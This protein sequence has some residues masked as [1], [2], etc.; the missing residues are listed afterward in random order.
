M[1]SINYEY[2][3]AGMHTLCRVKSDKVI[4]QTDK[5]IL[6]IMAESSS[7]RIIM[8]VCNF[9]PEFFKLPSG[10]IGQI[11]GKCSTYRVKLA[12][13]GDMSDYMTDNFKAFVN[14]TNRYGDYMFVEDENEVVRRWKEN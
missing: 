7:D 13:V 1:S 9:P 5:D 11:L 12:V 10:L 14:E 8:R 3:T 4:V 2:F 6:N